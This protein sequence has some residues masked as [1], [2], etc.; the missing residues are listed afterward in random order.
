MCFPHSSEFTEGLQGQIQFCDALI[1]Q[2]LIKMGK[3]CQVSVPMVRGSISVCSFMRNNVKAFFLYDLRLWYVNGGCIIF[4]QKQ[5]KHR[6]FLFFIT[7][8]NCN[9]QFR[10]CMHLTIHSSRTYLDL[11]IWLQCILASTQRRHPN[12]VNYL[13]LKTLAPWLLFMRTNPMSR[14]SRIILLVLVREIKLG[15]A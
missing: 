8:F 11:K 14:T 12:G 13:L 6:N 9:F 7:I 4:T 10:Y 3:N 5:N 15:T 1:F 2:Y